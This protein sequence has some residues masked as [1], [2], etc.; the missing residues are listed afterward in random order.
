MRWGEEGEGGGEGGG[1]GG[2]GGGEGEGERERGRGDNSRGLLE[3]GRGDPTHLTTRKSIP[4]S[5][6]HTVRSC[7]CHMTSSP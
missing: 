7:D 4:C 3:V 1:G 2:R 5:E 6:S